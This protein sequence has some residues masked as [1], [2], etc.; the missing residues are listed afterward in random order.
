MTLL[1]LNTDNL[2]LL[3]IKAQKPEDSPVAQNLYTKSIKG[4]PLSAPA[5][6]VLHTAYHKREKSLT[7][8]VK[9][10]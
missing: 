9:D 6:Q 3:Q 10:W 8:A 1:S 5:R 2:Y 4:S 7:A